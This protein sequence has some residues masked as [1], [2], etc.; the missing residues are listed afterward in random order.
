MS[1]G[2]AKGVVQ[3]LAEEFRTNTGAGLNGTFGAVHSI[4]EKLDADEPCDVI[5]LTGKMIADLDQMGRVESASCAELG[6]VET[7]L[8]VRTGEPLPAIGDSEELSASLKRSKGVYFPD[9][10][11]STAGIHFV[12]VL[13]KMGI[14]DNVEPFLRPFPNGAVAMANLAQRS[15]PG[16]IGCTQVTEI[17]YTQGVSLVGLLPK[18]FELSTVYSAA[19]SSKAA[20]PELAR[21]FVQLLTGS[22]T[23]TLRASSGFDV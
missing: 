9:P 7:G 5:I 11:R 14:Y 19:V 2:A 20:N 21:A 22:K 6:R 3:A 17:M 18:E 10:L 23:Q 15:E 16:L 12:A 8:A 13:R 1:A 4:R